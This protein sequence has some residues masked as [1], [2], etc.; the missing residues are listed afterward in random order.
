MA[1]RSIQS[2]LREPRLV[3]AI[4]AVVSLGIS[5]L[6][7]A[8][9]LYMLQIFDRVLQG[10]SLE[11]LLF[12]SLAVVFAL[13]VM[14]SLDACRAIILSRYGDW[15]EERLNGPVM[16]ATLEANAHPAANGSDQPLEDL[17]TIRN[18]LS[19]TAA[20]ALFDAPLM[21][22]F[23]AVIWLIH[24]LLGAVALGSAV[25]LA[26]LALASDL[27][28]RS[29]SKQAAG[30]LAASDVLRTGT[31]SHADTA[32]TMGLQAGL[33]AHWTALRNDAGKHMLTATSLL[34]VLTSTSKTL[35]LAVQAAI[36]G[37]GAYLVLERAITPGQMIA[38]SIILS[39]ALAPV[40][41]AIGSW[42]QVV[43][44]RQAWRRVVGLVMQHDAMPKGLDLPA[45]QGRLTCERVTLMRP[46]MKEPIVRAVSFEIPPGAVL[47]VAG[48]SGSGKSSLA[49]L[50]ARAWRPSDGTVRLDGADIQQWEAT[51]LGRH[52]G[53]LPQGADLYPGS[54][55]DNIARFQEHRLE[56]VVEAA[57]RARAHDLI[58]GLPGG[59]EAPVGAGGG[60][61]SGGQRQRVAL[62]RALF[63]NPR[64]VVLDEPDTNLDQSGHNA[65]LQTIGDLRKARVTLVIVAHR[66]MMLDLCDHLLMMEEGRVKTFG[67]AREV[68]ERLKYASGAT[69][70]HAVQGTKDRT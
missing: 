33:Q 59:Y 26:L 34:G 70:L 49:R 22:V 25:L 60:R 8:S 30:A 17:K 44:S 37:C 47:G 32:Q 65:L 55:R 5:L 12:L 16:A 41:T 24:P 50:I 7:L 11:T 38:S 51:A 66:R 31:V 4:L 62:A 46:G 39:R 56:E 40:E 57:R 6:M 68:A 19:S 35:R 69:P 28:T 63:G 27:M 23:I 67:P 14:G 48:A 58:V 15:L 21:P 20:G 2:T 53:Y 45:P 10:R 54:I 61:L 64:L 1:T 52:V 29:A 18:F 43:S 3:G 9:P 13:A 42:R 36:L